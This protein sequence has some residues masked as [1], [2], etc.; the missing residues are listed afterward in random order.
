MRFRSASEKAG[1]GQRSSAVPSIQE[2]T[3]GSDRSQRGGGSPTAQDAATQFGLE[4]Y[5]PGMEVQVQRLVQSHGASQV[6]QWAD[7]GMTVD[8]MGKPRDMRE[9][10]ERQEGRPAEVPKDIE[11]RNAKSVQRSR[12]AH[13]EASKAGDAQVPD[14]VRDV[15]SSPGQ[16]LDTSIQRAMEERMGDNL[17]DVR[18]HTGPNAAKACEDINARAFTVGN[19]IAFNHGEYDPSSAE[20]QH[21]LAHELAHVRQQTGGAVS[22]LP[23]TGELEIDPDQ[24]LEREAEETAQRVMRGGKLGIHRMRD[25]DV[26]IQWTSRTSERDTSSEHSEAI[27]LQRL[28][29]DERLNVA[30]EGVEAAISWVTKQTELSQS[31]ARVMVSEA[32]GADELAMFQKNVAALHTTA[33]IDDLPE[34]RQRQ[35]ARNLLSKDPLAL[36][37]NDTKV[38]GEIP[39]G[40]RRDINAVFGYS[41]TES[42]EVPD[43]GVN[44]TDPDHVIPARETRE[45]Y[46]NNKKRLRQEAEELREKSHTVEEVARKAVL[47]RNLDRIMSYITEGDREKIQSV[48]ERSDDSSAKGLFESIQPHIEEC[49]EQNLRTMLERNEKKYGKATGPN[50]DQLYQK[51]D[52]NWEVVIE[53]TTQ[54]NSAVNILVGLEDI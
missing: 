29:N 16:Q 23:Q 51:Y 17:G 13:H 24:Q 6:R 10:R 22:M 53:K 1:E 27:E 32:N 11:R 50:A 25:T 3:G 45:E 31:S 12:G 7:E 18:I 43:F 49:D 26:H 19:H 34:K 52:R 36:D 9:F 14:S 42:D 20:G 46:V 48:V 2:L 44:W 8:T 47:E 15:I 30:S 39:E 4:M 28:P 35:V 40:I 38:T 37:G 21:V 41:P 33:A 5:R 54:T